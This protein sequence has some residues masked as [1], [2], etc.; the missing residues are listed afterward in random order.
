MR[1]DGWDAALSALLDDWEARPIAYGEADCARFIAEAVA[2]QT[3]QDFYAP[4]RGK[5]KTLAASVRALRTIGAGDLSKTITA[6]LGEP[7]HPAFAGRGDVVM[8]DGNAGLCMGAVAWFVG[9][10]GLE[11]RATADAQIAWKV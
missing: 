3:G 6:A 8:M 7:M 4:F 2:V 11:K 1:V 9:E 5:Y 10:G